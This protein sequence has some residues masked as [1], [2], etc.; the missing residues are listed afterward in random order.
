MTHLPTLIAWHMESMVILAQ[1][2]NWQ[3]QEIN[4]TCELHCYKIQHQ[5]FQKP[6]LEM[7]QASLVISVSIL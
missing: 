7:Q 4:L 2:V 3:S 1:Q 6:Q 5:Q